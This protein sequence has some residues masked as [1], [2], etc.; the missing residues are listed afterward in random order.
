MSELAL[1]DTPEKFADEFDVSRETVARLEI[2]ERL[3]RQWQKGTNLVSPAT[4]DQIW[5]RHFADSAQLLNYA[6]RSADWIDMGTGAGFPGLVVAI[7]SANRDTGTVHLVESN[8]RK[9]AFVREVVRETGCFV[10]MH[11]TRVESLWGDD[12]LTGVGCITAR[13]LAPLSDLL[14]L[15]APFFGPTARGLFLKGGKAEV[16]LEDSAENWRFQA[17]MHPSITDARARIVELSDLRRRKS[18]NVGEADA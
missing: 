2:Y 12:R 8:A 7:C 4:L 14:E 5:H 11:Q 13:A 1:I 6:P 18:D 17:D 15:S 16:E 10:E 3:L 9:C